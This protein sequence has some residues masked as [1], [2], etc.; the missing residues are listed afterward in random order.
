M[1][2]AIVLDISLRTGIGILISWLLVAQVNWVLVATQSRSH[3]L[4]RCRTAAPTSGLQSL[5]CPEKKWWLSTFSAHVMQDSSR[6]SLLLS[7]LSSTLRPLPMSNDLTHTF[8][9]TCTRSRALIAS[10]LPSFQGW[11]TKGTLWPQCQKSSVRRS[12]LQV[13][14]LNTINPLSSLHAANLFSAFTRKISYQ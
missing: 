8:T 7:T 5:L 1:N 13:T 4:H 12:H 9:H 3:E 11:R 6:S 10:A 14:R 2:L